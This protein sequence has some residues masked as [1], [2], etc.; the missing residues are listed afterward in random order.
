MRKLEFSYADKSKKSIE[1]AAD[2]P[3]S[4]Q[5]RYELM[6]VPESEIT[7]RICYECGA[8]IVGLTEYD[9]HVAAHELT[10]IAWQLYALE[11]N[12]NDKE[13]LVL[14]DLEL[15]GESDVELSERRSARKPEKRRSV[16]VE[17]GEKT[18]KRRKAE[19]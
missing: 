14:Q 6:R 7:K 12:A 4:A 15:S 1:P 13:E 9:D 19:F 3:M 16:S 8:V 10:D 18:H 11:M 2:A 17:V 5:R